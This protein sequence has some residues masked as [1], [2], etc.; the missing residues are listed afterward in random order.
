MKEKLY[1]CLEIIENRPLCLKHR[2]YNFDLTWCFPFMSHIFLNYM[3]KYSNK[4]PTQ[5]IFKKKIK[6]HR[7][8]FCSE[9]SKDSENI[10]GMSIRRLSKW[11]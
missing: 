10:C 5:K 4:G 8:R 2:C 7:C 6:I 9:L 1:I 3:E 11:E